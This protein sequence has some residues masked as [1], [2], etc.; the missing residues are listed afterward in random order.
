MK[1]WGLRVYRKQEC[2]KA[3]G[4]VICGDTLETQWC[5]W[6]ET[7]RGVRSNGRRYTRSTIANVNSFVNLFI[8]FESAVVMY[9][10]SLGTVMA[11]GGVSNARVLVFSF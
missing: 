11:S 7:K 4:T 8:E 3:S 10:V 6:E 1:E 5:G 9:E 2:T